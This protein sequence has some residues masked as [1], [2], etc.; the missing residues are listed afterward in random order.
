[1][2]E[3]KQVIIVR[4]DTNPKMRKGKI[5]SQCCHA[6][7][8]VI[9]DEFFGDLQNRQWTINDDE[10]KVS[11]NVEMDMD[12]PLYIWLS[13][14][15][16]KIVLSGTLNDLITAYQ[17]AKMEGIPCSL[18][19]DKGLTEFGGEITITAVAIGPY[20]PDKI[21]KITGHLELL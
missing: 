9:L 14:I 1:M 10:R 16:K 3:P 2:D 19:E 6:S 21:D 15:F 4:T 11:I 17:K 12:S 7:M 18:I 8:G 20:Y 13:T 5:A